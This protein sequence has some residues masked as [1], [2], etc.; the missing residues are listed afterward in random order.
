MEHYTYASSFLK[1]QSNLTLLQ[2]PNNNV[3]DLSETDSSTEDDEETNTTKTKM[4]VLD[5]LK[6]LNQFNLKAAF[7]NMCTAYKYVCT[8]PTTSVSCER[9]FS[10]LKIIKTR[11]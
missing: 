5:V 3:N 9:H 1:L 4:T 2:L 8:I 11:L 7:P 10:I 6:F